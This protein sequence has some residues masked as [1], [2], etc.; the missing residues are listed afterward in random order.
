M[1]GESLERA[2]RRSTS[3]RGVVCPVT[4]LESLYVLGKVP[5]RY[6]GPPSHNRCSPID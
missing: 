3:A 2:A 6:L 1:D 4:T 5:V